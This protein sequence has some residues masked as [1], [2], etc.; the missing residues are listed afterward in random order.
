MDNDKINVIPREA[1]VKITI[2]G[3]FYE[4]LQNS[5]F[6]LYRESKLNTKELTEVL[7]ELT[8]KRPAENFFEEQVLTYLALL[9]AVDDAAIKQKLVKKAPLSDFINDDSAQ[10]TSPEN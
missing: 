4:R 1:L 6:A 9:A 3:A 2:S 7:T 5:L 10:E 8:A